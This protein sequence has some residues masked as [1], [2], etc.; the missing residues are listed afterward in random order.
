MQRKWWHGKWHIRWL[1]KS[2]MIPTGTAGIDL[3]GIISKL[4]Y[5]ERL[6]V[7]IVWISIYA[8]LLPGCYDISDYYKIDPPSAP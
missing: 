5:L 1:S 2:F 6:G 8:S 7:D 4:D 3:P